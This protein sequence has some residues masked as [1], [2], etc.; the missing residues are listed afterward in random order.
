MEADMATT[1][2]RKAVKVHMSGVSY[3]IGANLINARHMAGMTQKALAE[4]AGLSSR[5]VQLIEA[6][7]VSNVTVGT[8]EA[9]GKVL[10]LEVAE[11]FKRSDDFVNV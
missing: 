8:L 2:S 9:L 1:K 7:D 4:K 10:G 3:W 5:T 11:F 6:E